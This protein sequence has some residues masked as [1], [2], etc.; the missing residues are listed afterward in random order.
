MKPQDQGDW[1]PLEERLRQDREAREPGEHFFASMRDDIMAQLPP[2]QPAALPG[3]L[4]EPAPAQ[5]ASPWWRRL[6][7]GFA[8][9]P[10]LSWGA[11]MAAALLGLLLWPGDPQPE[12]PLAP[13]PQHAGALVQHS[14]SPQEVEELRQMAS[15]MKIDILAEDDGWG[16]V[17][18][19]GG[20]AS[21]GGFAEEDPGWLDEDDL[22]RAL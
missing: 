19:E 11:V 5:A 20:E 6:L 7:E 15:E 4:V 18:A 8:Q 14:L 2:Q 21:L 12:A 16:A 17:A 1:T 9:R 10:T 13:T 22:D 3:G